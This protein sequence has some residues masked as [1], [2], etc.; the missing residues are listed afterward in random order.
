MRV[1]SNDSVGNLS[2][3]KKSAL[4]ARASRSES[5]V[6]TGPPLATRRIVVWSSDTQ[7]RLGELLSVDPW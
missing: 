4:L 6:L 3:S 7:R 5:R 1:E 2:A